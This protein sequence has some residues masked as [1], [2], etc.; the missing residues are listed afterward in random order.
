MFLQLS[1]RGGDR[2]RT[3]IIRQSQGRE[4]RP[5]GRV[6]P[7]ALPP[8]AA[9]TSSGRPFGD[10]NSCVN[11]VAGIARATGVPR[12]TAATCGPSF[13][14]DM[15]HVERPRA[16]GPA[17]PQLPPAPPVGRARSPDD[18]ISRLL[19]ARTSAPDAI[20]GCP[21]SRRLPPK[22]PPADSRK[23]VAW[24]PM[25]AWPW[26]ASASP[27]VTGGASAT[28]PLGRGVSTFIRPRGVDVAAAGRI[29]GGR[30]PSAT[31]RVDPRWSATHAPATTLTANRVPP[32]FRGARSARLL[33]AGNDPHREPAPPACYRRNRS[34]I[35]TL[36]CPTC[37]G[38]P[39]PPQHLPR[40]RGTAG[41]GYS[42]ARA[43]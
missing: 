2:G 35:A 16:R 20:R 9:M 5:S 42:T 39:G 7:A 29:P 23:A 12:G 25:R 27:R 22:S 6:A 43:Q 21:P 40:P 30:H 32:D 15:F 33:C 37:D 13:V 26:R 3:V 18:S 31:V 14:R 1:L 28:T 34:P 10:R 11:G 17:R 38:R 36:G 8:P 4:K 41:S 24:A 19:R